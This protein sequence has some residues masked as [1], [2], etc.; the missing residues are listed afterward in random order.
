MHE[1]DIK[2]I[3]TRY[4]AGT[5]TGPEKELLE[6]FFTENTAEA[7][8]EQINPAE[9]KLLESRLR[10]KIHIQLTSRLRWPA[11]VWRVAASI[12]F[13]AALVIVYRLADQKENATP[14]V[15]TAELVRTTERGQKVTIRLPDGTIVKLNSSSKL[16]FPD[17]FIGY[18]REVTLDGEGYFEVVHNPSLPFIVH[19]NHSATQVLG[20]SFNVNAKSSSSTE[21]TLVTGRVKVS[22]VAAETTITLKPSQQAIITQ[23]KKMIDTASVDVTRFIEWKDNIVTFDDTPLHQVVVKLE[24]WY[25]VEIAVRSKAI[26]SCRITARYESESLENV[27]ESLEFLLKGDY[28][29]EGKN[30]TLSG[31]GCN[32][33]NKPKQ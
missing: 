12:T 20:T 15:Q 1:N 14:S 31:E 5:A 4:L 9:Y 25:G 2:N 21:V 17:K 16:I 23:G 22:G 19:T 29:L 3:L 18:T 8:Q 28:T 26:E 10:Q 27:L 11:I 32:A 7:L 24:E 33:T 6:R 30:V 13:I